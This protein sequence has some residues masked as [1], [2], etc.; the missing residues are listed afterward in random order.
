LC[1][2]KKSSS[3]ER[4]GLKSKDGTQRRELLQSSFIGHRKKAASAVGGTGTPRRSVLRCH[5]TASRRNRSGGGG[6]LG[7]GTGTPGSGAKQCR[8]S[9]R[10]TGKTGPGA[11]PRSS[12]AVVIHLLYLLQQSTSPSSQHPFLQPTASVSP[13]P[14]HT[15]RQHIANTNYPANEPRS[16][17]HG[18]KERITFLPSKPAASNLHPCRPVDSAAAGSWEVDRALP[19]R[20]LLLP[21]TMAMPSLTAMHT[22]SS[23]DQQARAPG[24]TPA[25]S[26]FRPTPATQRPSPCRPRPRAR[27]QTFPRTSP[28][29][30]RSVRRGRPGLRPVPTSWHVPYVRRKWYGFHHVA[31][32]G[33]EIKTDWPYGDRSHSSN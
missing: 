25:R 33:E 7:P 24:P 15:K 11:W 18:I 8:G 5:C 31:L 10:K 1:A 2:K 12:I 4:R 21:I 14:L 29:M 26:P 22:L 32:E 16:H 27:S 23:I 6:I 19:C 9:L 28:P 30:S 17:V 13:P 3:A 20:H